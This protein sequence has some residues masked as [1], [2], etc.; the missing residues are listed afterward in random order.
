MLLLADALDVVR[1]FVDA[2]FLVYILLVLISILLSWFQLP[3][4]PWLNRFL[5]F[6]DDV[7]SPYLRIFRRFLPPLRMGAVGLD[8]SP[9]V[10]I[11]V[12]YILRAVVLRVIDSFD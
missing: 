1:R 9:I 5:R 4:N 3:Y 7:V 10:G 11:F 6:L 8:L 2:V 12:L